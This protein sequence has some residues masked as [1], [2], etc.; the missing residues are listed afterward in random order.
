[1]QAATY[2]LMGGSLCWIRFRCANAWATSVNESL[3]TWSWSMSLS[4]SNS[5]WSRGRSW[6]TG[7]GLPGRHV[8]GSSKL[9]LASLPSTPSSSALPVASSCASSPSSSCSCSSASGSGDDRSDSSDAGEGGVGSFPRR[10]L[11]RGGIVR[12]RFQRLR[13]GS[14]AWS[15]VGGSIAP[16]PMQCRWLP[17]GCVNCFLYRPESGN[18]VGSTRRGTSSLVA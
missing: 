1:M 11:R 14:L 5:L 7:I 13:V 16:S 18:R 4:S 9:R 8:S 2:A 10:A 6:D 15:K 17:R 3:S 12:G